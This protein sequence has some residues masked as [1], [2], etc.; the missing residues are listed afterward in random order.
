MYSGFRRGCLWARDIFADSHFV[1]Q[2]EESKRPGDV[3]W[4]AKTKEESLAIVKMI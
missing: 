1:Y 3:E 4:N 2:P